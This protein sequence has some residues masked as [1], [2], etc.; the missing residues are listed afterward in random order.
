MLTWSKTKSSSPKHWDKLEFKLSTDPIRKSTICN[1]RYIRIPSWLSTSENSTS[2][3]KQENMRQ[4]E[5]QWRT[6]ENVSHDCL[7]RSNGCEW[8]CRSM[9]RQPLS[10]SDIDIIFILATL[11]KSF[12]FILVIIEKR[13][14][15]GWSCSLQL[16]AYTFT[17]MS[18]CYLIFAYLN[19]YNILIQISLHV[20]L[21][22]TC[23]PVVRCQYPFCEATSLHY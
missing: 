16:Y 22:T 4:R 5:S 7:Y 23:G 20:F 19:E 14:L 18:F 17:V 6:D 1:G 9:G 3:E 21:E 13:S 11:K 12:M 15:H 10:D 2:S 8:R